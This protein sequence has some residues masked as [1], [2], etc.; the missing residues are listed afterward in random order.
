MNRLRFLGK[1]LTAVLLCFAVVRVAMHFSEDFRFAVYHVRD[2]IIMAQFFPITPKFWAHR[3]NDT[4]KMEEMMTK[5]KGVE[6]DVFFRPA[7]NGGSFEVSHNRKPATEHSLESFFALLASSRGTNCWLDF[8]N[9]NKV[10]AK[11]ALYELERLVT[12]YRIDKN[13]LIV[14][15]PNYALLGAFRQQG[16]YTSYY[17]P[18]DDK[19]YLNTD[20]HREAFTRLVSKAVKSGNVDAVSFPISYYPLVKS[21]NAGVDYL[22]WHVGHNGWID[23]YFDRKL[24]DVFQD[25]EV[26][27]ILVSANSRYN[28]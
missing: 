25:K 28:R 17:C 10:T 21:A 6:L 14:E 1:A 18:V 4:R 8:K 12:K 11:P 3:C 13:R 16:Y 7:E 2:D 19:R 5:Y 15:S 23:F 26:K 9:L 20:A 24:K 22:T 27:V